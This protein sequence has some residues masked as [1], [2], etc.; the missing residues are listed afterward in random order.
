MAHPQSRSQWMQDS[1]D[2]F[3]TGQSA[4]QYARQRRAARRLHAAL[5]VLEQV[6]TEVDPE[7]K[8]KD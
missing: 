2:R 5:K 7:D 6:R 3:R 8:W 4:G 1:D